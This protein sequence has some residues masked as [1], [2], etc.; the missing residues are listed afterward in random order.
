MPNVKIDSEALKAFLTSVFAKTGMPQADAEFAAWSTVQS[1]LWGIDSHGTLRT[2]D[3]EKRLRDKVVNPAPKIVNKLNPALPIGHI[4]GDAGLG[5][6]VGRDGMLLAIEKAKTFGV[7][8]IIASNSNHYGAAGIYARMAAA[9]GLLGLTVTNV[10]P[11]IGMPGV[12]APVSGNNPIALAA[13]IPDSDP[14]C[15]DVAM[16]MVALGKLIYAKKKGVSI[17]TGWATDR[18]G[19]DTTDPDEGIKGILLPTGM[20]KG[21]GISLFIDILTGLLGG[22]PFLSQMISMYSHPDKPSNLA[23]AFIAINIDMFMERSEY[24][25]RILEWRDIL[26]NTPVRAGLPPLIIP[27]EPEIES[28][29]ER[30]A[31]GITLPAQLWADL[32]AIAKVHGLPVPAVA[33]A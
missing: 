32:Q 7:S 27:G 3:Y 4:D 33:E 19:N 31:N 25:K 12:T 22:G 15:I 18:A 14:F 29:K 5:Y 24:N 13:P 16:S 1:D 21:F 26:H 10:K 9:E 6:I 2:P 17:P 20:H 11:N 30:R 8:L 28:E 23:H